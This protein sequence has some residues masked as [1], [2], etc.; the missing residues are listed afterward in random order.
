MTNWSTTVSAPP[1]IT[2]TYPATRGGSDTSQNGSSTLVGTTRDFTS[3]RVSVPYTQTQSFQV[4]L[5]STYDSDIDFGNGN[6]GANNGN[7]S[8][9]SATQGNNGNSGGKLA[10]SATVSIPIVAATGPK[11]TLNTATL[12]I[13]SGSND[14]HQFTITAGQTDLSNVTLALGTPPSGLS[15]VTANV[16]SSFST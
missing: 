11:L 4:T 13:Q 16:T 15:A 6:G 14:Y 1:G 8:G 2:I 5:R 7:H 12:S 10:T 9:N 3:F